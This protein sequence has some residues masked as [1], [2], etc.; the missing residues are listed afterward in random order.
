MVIKLFR[1]QRVISPYLIILSLVSL[2]GALLGCSRS[3]STSIPEKQKV[4]EKQASENAG[5]YEKA[6]LAQYR[7]EVPLH[8][9]WIEKGLE[10]GE[11]YRSDSADMSIMELAKAKDKRAVSVLIKVMKDYSVTEA[12]IDAAEALGVINDRA[13]IPALKDALQDKDYQVKVAAAEA[14]IA[15]GDYKAALPILTQVALKEEIEKWSVDV[16]YNLSRVG[17]MEK[18]RRELASERKERVLPS[19]AIRVLAKTDNVGVINVFIKCL[20]DRNISVRLT[21]ASALVD[22]KQESEVMR[23]LENIAYNRNLDG[24]DRSE[25]INI[26]AKTKSRNAKKILQKLAGD[27]DDYV[28][29]EAKEALHK[30]N[31][32][33]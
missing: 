18:E 12:R 9:E 29:R 33:K 20:L 24:F 6:K 31:Q 3:D 28:A 16:D 17:D 1:L 30:I 11:L 4:Q 8:I 5:E 27:K 32:A 22:F 14:L 13:A 2:D 23:V 10:R 7:S 25:A 15:F 19:Q 26:L 21:A